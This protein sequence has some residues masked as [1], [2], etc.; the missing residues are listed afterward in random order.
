MNHEAHPWCLSLREPRTHPRRFFSWL[1]ETAG[2]SAGARRLYE[3][4]VTV[5]RRG[6]LLGFKINGAGFAILASRIF[7]ALT[8]VRVRDR[9][10]WRMKRGDS[11]FRWDREG[12]NKGHRTD[13]GMKI[14]GTEERERERGGGLEREDDQR[15]ENVEDGIW[16]K[17]K[18]RHKPRRKRVGGLEL[19]RKDE[20]EREAGWIKGWKKKGKDESRW[21][22]GEGRMVV[23]KRQRKRKGRRWS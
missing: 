9:C 21:G 16:T 23:I 5:L 4:L 8:S 2:P 12:G 22:G 14:T 19:Y 10:E 3:S 20:E 7:A 18:K 6:D 13:V 11:G 1:K 17:R 15:K